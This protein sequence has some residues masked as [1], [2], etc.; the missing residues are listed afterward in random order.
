MNKII[1]AEDILAD[2][3]HCVECLFMA[4]RGLP[5]EKA[6]PIQAVADIA[7]DKINE[8]IALLSEYRESGE[9]SPVPAAAPA[10]Q[11]SPPTRTKRQSK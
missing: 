2:A 11:K 1:D 5:R 4:A 9:A 7:S 8:A 6:G 10:K 3:R